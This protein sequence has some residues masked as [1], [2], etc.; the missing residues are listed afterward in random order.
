M[1]TD[2]RKVA[3]VPLEDRIKSQITV[4][5]N[6]CWEWRGSVTTHGYGRMSY[7][8]R[9]RRVHRLSAHLWLGLDL[10]NSE[11]KVLHSCDNPPC[12]NPD[13]LRAGTQKEN[14]REM[15]GRGR[16]YR[17]PQ[18]WSHC[19]R[20]HRLTPDNTIGKKARC[21]VCAARMN[22]EYRARRALTKALE[23]ER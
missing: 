23:G 19:L 6:G 12:C 8:N 18:K 3:L 1:G 4:T 15:V 2:G 22:R 10:D 9:V 20:G 14:V 17:G 21:G 13:H 5:P 11:L 16:G 7:L